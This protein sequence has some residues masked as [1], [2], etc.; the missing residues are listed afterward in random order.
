MARGK[1]ITWYVQI[2]ENQEPFEALF[3]SRLISSSCFMRPCVLSIFS[4]LVLS[5]V[6]RIAVR[7]RLSGHSLEQAR[8]TLQYQHQRRNSCAPACTEYHRQA[9]RLCSAAGR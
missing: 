4:E 2:A 1:I 3:S 6:Q 5:R 7:S 9:G 8:C